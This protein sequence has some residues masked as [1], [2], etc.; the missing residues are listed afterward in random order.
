MSASPT[1]SAW[2]QAAAALGRRPLA[3]AGAVVLAGLAWGASLLI[4]MAALSL[5]PLLERGTLAPTATAVLAAAASPAEADAAAASM[6]QLPAVLEVRLVPRDAALAQI[7]QRSAADR[8]AVG[9]LAAN[10]LPDVLVVTFRPAAG[11]DAV[12]ATAAASRKV[13]RVEQVTL[14]LGWYRKLW[15][16]GQVGLTAGALIA[17][18]VL[19]QAV[20]WLLVAVCLSADLP[21]GRVRLLWLLG[22]DDR[23]LRRAPMLGAAWTALAC[24]AVAL[25]SAR[26]GWQWLDRELG[27]LGQLYGQPVPLLWPAPLWLGAAGG[28]ILILGMAM[29]MVR[30]QTRL[31]AI[32]RR[33]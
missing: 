24:A 16:L 3:W 8:E 9:Q 32:R 21:P 2:R 31:G 17:G 4:V 10:P 19:L 15:A 1:A 23:R 28:A 26:A 20:V 12:E 5:R 33:N 13:A 29:G 6:R 22:A 14:D 18:A 27:H 7:A 30:A 25:A 11:P